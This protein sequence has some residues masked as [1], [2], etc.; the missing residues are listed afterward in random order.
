MEERW[1]QPS[2]A[3]V[4]SGKTLAQL[5]RHTVIGV[6]HALSRNEDIN[7]ACTTRIHAISNACDM[8]LYD[9][10]VASAAPPHQSAGSR[11]SKEW[12][13]PAA[14][15]GQLRAVQRYRLHCRPYTG[16]SNR[17]SIRENLK[18]GKS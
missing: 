14:C 18:V 7:F 1:N 11:L 4:S 2:R 5:N 17:K 9:R 12:S 6:L 8:S 3:T 10:S 16:A 13:L 15:L